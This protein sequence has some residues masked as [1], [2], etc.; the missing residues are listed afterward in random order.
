METP[1][2]KDSSKIKG[3]GIT[4][5]NCGAEL[6]L[7]GVSSMNVSFLNERIREGNLDEAISLA[8]VAWNNFP[9]LK[10]STESKAVI[11]SLLDSVEGKVQQILN[12]LHN[13]TST[14]IA[15]STSMAELSKQLPENLRQDFG[16]KIDDLQKQ[17]Q[18]VQEIV[19][20]PPELLVQ[21]VT[22]L[23][24][25]INTMMNKP[26]SKGTFFESSLAQLWQ[27]TFVKD[28]VTQKGGAGRSDLLIIPHLGTKYGEKISI[29]RKAGGQGYNRAHVLEAVEHARAEGA[30][31]A[32]V[33]Y[34]ASQ[35]IP[36]NLGSLSIE[37][38][39]NVFVAITDA[40][41]GW[42]VGRYVIGVFQNALK[43]EEGLQGVDL[44]EIK[45]IVAEM[46]NFNKEI[47]KLRKKNESAIKACQAVTK[48]INSL[49]ELFGKY[50]DR[51]QLAL[52]PEQQGGN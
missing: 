11:D 4:C 26:V 48:M 34:D 13:A 37:I 3:M 33:L 45:N 30:K 35:N 44:K 19:S 21:Q 14:L 31:Y 41:S 22:G 32:L 52:N 50:L 29:E 15:L 39:D 27:A 47:E 5:S 6:E 20:K 42:K 43:T 24:D 10:L 17:V 51:L 12:P 9:E 23:R 38:V 40:Q 28:T 36:D 7:A 49:Q 46:D 16:K 18:S 8:R 1:E 2:S 25:T